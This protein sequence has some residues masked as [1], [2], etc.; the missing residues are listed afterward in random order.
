MDVIV[1]DPPKT[2]LLTVHKEVNEIATELRTSVAA[3]TVQINSLLEANLA[4]ILGKVS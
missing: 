2:Q 3:L 4:V 1:G